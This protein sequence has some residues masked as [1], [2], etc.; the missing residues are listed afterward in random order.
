MS[1]QH[2]KWYALQVLANNEF[3]A[4]VG[5]R[6]RDYSTYLPTL[7][8]KQRWSDRTKTI[9][10]PMFPGYIFSRFDAMLPYRMVDS[11]RV[12]RIVG[13]RGIPIPIA[14]SELD[15]VRILANSGL[16]VH[17]WLYLLEGEKVRVCCG[18]LEGLEG[19][20]VRH[21]GQNRIVVQVTILQ[22]SVVADLEGD[23]VIPLRPLQLPG[24]IPPAKS[25]S[26][27]EAQSSLCGVSRIKQNG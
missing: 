9:H 22:R 6:V 2:D 3:A 23:T 5:L 17:P 18:V 15:S 24:A 8:T 12:I 21:R 7:M 14:E 16:V 1:L 20:F 26:D 4:E 27:P 13:S 11:P 19:I 25:W 10:K